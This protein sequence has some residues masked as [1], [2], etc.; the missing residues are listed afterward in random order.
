MEITIGIVEDHSEFRNSLVF[1]ISSFTAYQVVWAVGSVREAMDNKEPV[2]IILLDINLPN[3][4]GIQGIPLFK[5]K[6]PGQKIIML[7]IQDDE[8]SILSAIKAGADGYILK[9]TSPQKI[10][11]A[12]QQVYEGGAALTPMVAKQ[13]LALFKPKKAVKVTHTSLT[14]REKEILTLITQGMSTLVI[15]ETLFISIQT[16][17]N[18]IKSIYEKLHVHSKA[19]AVAIA[20]KEKIV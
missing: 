4:S 8:E 12:I 10:L 20:L 1:L 14:P 5:A 15:A 13:V 17:R 19:H 9:K 3:L 2:D 11:E 18:H 6:F 16:V 7:T